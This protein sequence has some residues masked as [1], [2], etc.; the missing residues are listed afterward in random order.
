MASS[1]KG[2]ASRPPFAAHVLYF[3][4]HSVLL[5]AKTEPMSLY[6]RQVN[7]EGNS[8]LFAY[9][10]FSTAAVGRPNRPIGVFPKVFV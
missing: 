10:G 8:C 5:L 2:G 7:G 1:T 6:R 4:C 9:R 3:P